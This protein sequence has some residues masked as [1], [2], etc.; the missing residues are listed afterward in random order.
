MKPAHPRR[1]NHARFKTTN[2]AEDN[3][4][5][6][7]S[8]QIETSTNS[9]VVAKKHASYASLPGRISGW[10]TNILTAAIAVAIGLSLGWQLIGWLRPPSSPALIADSS[11]TA[12][13]STIT[14]EHEFLTSS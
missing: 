1:S 5:A 10:T 8:G 13:L 12:K 14:D 2:H 6:I 4:R 7:L 11:T 9:S 3:A